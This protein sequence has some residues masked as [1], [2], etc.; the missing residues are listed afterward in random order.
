LLYQLA[1]VFL[2]DIR[3]LNSMQR[4]NGQYE[5][6]RDAKSCYMQLDFLG[7]GNAQILHVYPIFHRSI[8]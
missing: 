1:A 2:V 5:V 6:V 4:S 7:F 3:S 8:L